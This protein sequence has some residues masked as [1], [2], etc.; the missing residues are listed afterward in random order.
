MNGDPKY[1]KALAIVFILGPA[2]ALIGLIYLLAYV[3]ADFVLGGKGL[4]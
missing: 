3:D 1:E 2:V 4:F